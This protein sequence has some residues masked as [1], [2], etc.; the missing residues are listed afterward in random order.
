MTIAYALLGL[1]E[2]AS[3][4]GYDLKHSYDRRFGGARPVRFGQVYRTLAQLERDGRVT[5]L[6]VEAG[7]G[8][9]RRRYAITPEG[10]T[11]LGAWL[12]E[13]EDPQPQLQTVLFTK[14]TLALMSG[15]PAGAYLDAQ[16]TRH[17]AVMQRLTA[18]RRTAASAR[19]AMLIDYQLFHVEA[20]LRWLDHA[21]SRLPTL[22]EECR[23]ES[24]TGRS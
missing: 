23:D 5:A 24:D 4:H 16:R 18:A 20:D 6:G 11:G 7:G 15:R 9:E 14:V 12:A 3:R 1:L 17:L 8:P 21:E 19:D 13:P 2:G 22:A 10:V